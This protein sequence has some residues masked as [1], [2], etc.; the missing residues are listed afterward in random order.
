MA[1]GL[2]SPFGMALNYL[3]T[4]V[5]W[6]PAFCPQSGRAD[7]VEFFTLAP[8]RVLIDLGS[9]EMQTGWMSSGYFKDLSPFICITLSLHVRVA[10]VSMR[11]PERWAPS[12]SLEMEAHAR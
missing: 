4:L 5:N 7:A 3:C 9:P 11:R 2:P 6:F 8:Q 1:D 12:S 10:S